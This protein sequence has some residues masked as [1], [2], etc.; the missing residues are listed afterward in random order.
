MKK[1]LIIKFICLSL[2]LNIQAQ[3]KPVTDKVVEASE[4]V[5]KKSKQISDAS[6][7]VADQAGQAG[8]NAKNIVSN[9][10]AII[11]V[12]EPIFKLHFKKK[13]KVNLPVADDPVVVNTSQA[14]SDN[15]NTGT[16]PPPP[17]PEN[18]NTNTGDN[19]TNNNYGNNPQQAAPPAYSDPGVP[20]NTNYNSDGTANWGN[21]QNA[22]YGCYLDALTGT[23]LDGGSAEDKPNAIDL[24]FLAPSDGQNAYYLMTPNFAHDNGTANAMWGS[25]STDN[26]V[27]TWKSVNESEVA[28]TNLTGAQFEKIQYNEQLRG[29]VKGARNYSA[30][31]TSINKLDGKVFAVKTTMGERDAFALIYV[32]KHIGTS[33]SGGYLKVKIKCTGFDNT[34][35][36]NPDA[37]IYSRQ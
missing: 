28:A 33:G 12:F 34:G 7:K 9:V 20:E 27:K 3:K 5:N 15:T 1:I 36:G 21:Q 29:A 35:D 4:K 18:S 31:Y 19:N 10:K 11:K 6:N 22:E 26:P 16:P 17:A 8:E 14:K 32:V 30:V 23:I 25:N 24:I 13:N 2:F 37:G